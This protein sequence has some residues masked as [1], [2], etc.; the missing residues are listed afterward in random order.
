MSELRFAVITT[1]HE[2]TFDY[3]PFCVESVQAQAAYAPGNY[4]YR[5]VVVND[6]SE[7]T[8][9]YLDVIAR[10][11]PNILPVNLRENQGQLLALRAGELALINMSVDALDSG[12]PMKRTLP[13]YSVIVDGDDGLTP[14][15]L[16]D[17]SKVVQVQ[18]NETRTLPGMMFGT[19][20]ILDGHGRE[21]D[22]VP[23][24]PGYNNIPDTSDGDSFLLR[25]KECNHLPSKPA[26]RFEFLS[27][28]L[29]NIPNTLN[30]N[31][32]TCVDWLLAIDGLRLSRRQRGSISGYVRMP[33]ATSYYR[34]RLGQS[35]VI[36]SANGT[37][38]EERL[39]LVEG[40]FDPF[41]DV[42]KVTLEMCR[43]L[44]WTPSRR[45]LD[46]LLAAEEQ[47]K[48]VA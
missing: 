48:A 29:S 35:S 14:T 41:S 38:E 43:K 46:E 26:L 18:W 1:T 17:Y 5:H 15:A 9:N 36:D 13:N 27:S 34:V 21:L 2:S 12:I 19:A 40:Q 11:D 6:G 3:L 30:G 37:W 16:Y 39:H 32:I 24:M 28:C 20:V 22:D 25:M 4:S 33:V 8:R 7:R 44:G 31:R 42:D 23:H 47:R 10:E 45:V